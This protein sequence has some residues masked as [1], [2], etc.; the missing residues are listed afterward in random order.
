M[1]GVYV[2]LVRLVYPGQAFELVA[3]FAPTQ[4]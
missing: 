1:N 4:S 2:T 3:N